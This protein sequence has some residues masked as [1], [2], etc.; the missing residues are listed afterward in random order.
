MNA[1]G[2][3]DP[4]ISKM[5]PR[6]VYHTTT[7]RNA[8]KIM[9]EGF[10][11]TMGNAGKPATY[12]S[13]SKKWSE[14]FGLAYRSPAAVEHYAMKRGLQPPPPYAHRMRRDRIVTA[15]QVGPK[16]PDR[17]ARGVASEAHA[18][19][20]IPIKSER[21]G[22]SS[23]TKGERRLAAVGGATVAGGGGYALKKKDA[24]AHG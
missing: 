6:M 16:R 18:D 15:M 2:V 24:K 11:D 10:K 4:R 21:V 1:F 8:G 7:A 14:R 22:Y 13:R 9:R 12:V 5:A 17:L 23:T 19:E 3:D 20:L